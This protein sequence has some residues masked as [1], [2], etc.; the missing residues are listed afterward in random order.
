MGG[1]LMWIGLEQIRYLKAVSD[2]G[3]FGAASK[4]LHRAKS[5][6][7][8]GIQNLEDQ[9][10]FKLL[11]RSSYRVKLTTKG[12]AF[13]FRAKRLLEESEGLRDYARL[14]ASDLEMKLT[15]SATMLVS[16][17]KI[18]P[19]LSLV[20]EKF[21]KTEIEFHREVMSGT[22]M[23]EDEVTDVALIAGRPQ[24]DALNFRKVS[25]SPMPIC[26]A[27]HHEFWSLDEEDQSKKALEAYPNIVQASTVPDQR[28]NPTLSKRK[29]R[30]HDHD[31][32][33][34]LI[35]AGL[36]W[37]RLPR[38]IVRND[39]ESGALKTFGKDLEV[40]IYIARRRDKNLGQ[41]GQYIWDYFASS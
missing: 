1:G 18:I 22:F 40:E 19:L 16:I 36:G 38:D 8:A 21:P 27:P 13:L 10:G 5:A 34:A 32:K 15:F 35:K 2:S 4:V 11:D 33:V 9:V 39:I 20:G 14:I 26:L 30:V 24:N 7:S 12:N 28:D 17:E 3:S 29:W 41:V 6:I 25:T 37:G 23:L 31:S